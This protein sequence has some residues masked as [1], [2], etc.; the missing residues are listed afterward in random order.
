MKTVIGPCA[1]RRLAAFSIASLSF[2]KSA[3]SVRISEAVAVPN[4]VVRISIDGRPPNT[5]QEMLEFQLNTQRLVACRPG[6]YRI[7]MHERSHRKSTR[8]TT[9]R[10]HKV[11]KVENARIEHATQECNKID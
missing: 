3:R 1:G 5:E 11:E 9:T 8:A 4:T 7:P 2:F 6:G 10:K